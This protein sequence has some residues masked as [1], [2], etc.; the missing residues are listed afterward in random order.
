MK[1]ATVIIR[2]S[3]FNTVRNSEAL[4]MSVGLTLANNAV[5][6]VFVDDGVLTLLPSSPEGI[7]IGAIDKH[8]QTLELLKHRL[9]VEQESLETIGLRAK[10]LQHKVEILS[11]SQIAAL[12]AESESIIAY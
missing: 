2:K 4:R 8:V 11:R 7:G 10:D 1:K 9:I 12:I 3:P 6:V 5:H